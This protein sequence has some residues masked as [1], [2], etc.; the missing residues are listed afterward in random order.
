[1]PFT[2]SVLKKILVLRTVGERGNK[3]AEKKEKGGFHYAITERRGSK[4]A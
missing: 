3:T 4:G 2:T 1:M